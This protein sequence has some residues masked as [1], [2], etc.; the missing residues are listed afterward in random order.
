[1][2]CFLLHRQLP[3]VS[4]THLHLVGDA[5]PPSHPLLSPSLAFSLSKHQGLFQRVSSS[6]EVA[7]VLELQLQLQSFQ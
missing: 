5:I 1:M 4:Q 2:D 6:H 3:E 7:K